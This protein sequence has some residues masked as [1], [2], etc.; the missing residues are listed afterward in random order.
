MKLLATIIVVL[1]L[2]FSSC[3]ALK[4]LVCFP[5]AGKSHIILGQALVNGL[6]KHGHNVTM[7]TPFSIKIQSDNFREVLIDNLQAK[8]YKAAL[9]DLAGKLKIP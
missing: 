7:V 4:I 5:V 8:T 9:G 2:G 1:F 3:D 6:I